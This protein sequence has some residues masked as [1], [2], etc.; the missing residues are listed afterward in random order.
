MDGSFDKFTVWFW[1]KKSW[2]TPLCWYCN[3][4]DDVF[5]QQIQNYLGGC[6]LH[7]KRNESGIGNLARDG[8]GL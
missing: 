1:H 7:A 3:F 8:I 2:G 6:R 4:C 5:L